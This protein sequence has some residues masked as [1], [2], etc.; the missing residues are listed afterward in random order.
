MPPE[1]CTR[2]SYMW[3]GVVACPKRRHASPGC[4]PRHGR[5]RRRHLEEGN[6]GVGSTRS[7]CSCGFGPDVAPRC[8]SGPTRHNRVERSN[9]ARPWEVKGLDLVV[10]RSRVRRDGGPRGAAMPPEHRT[11]PSH[12][13]DGAVACLKRR[14]ASPGCGPRHGRCRRRHL[15]GGNCRVG[16]TR[17]GFSY[18]FGPDV[19]PRCPSGR[20]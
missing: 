1:R 13:R 12:M 20:T 4:G 11:W 5:R 2:P 17:S 16:S 19:A 9:K 10:N 3:G 6:A 18:G 8:P 15:E 14:H 7:G